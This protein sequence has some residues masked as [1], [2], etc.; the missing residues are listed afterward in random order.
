MEDL[1]N[2][3]NRA[4][5]AGKKPA[6][7]VFLLTVASP[8]SYTIYVEAESKEQARKAWE[9]SDGFGLEYGCTSEDGEDEAEFILGV[10]DSD[11]EVEE[12]EVDYDEVRDALGLD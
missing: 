9:K 4:Q 3:P 1:T 10:E 7:E 6:T 12:A 8:R 2:T 5:E 11:C